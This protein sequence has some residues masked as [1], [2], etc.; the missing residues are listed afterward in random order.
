MAIPNELP[1]VCEQSRQGPK[2]VLKL[3]REDE[4]SPAKKDKHL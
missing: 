1:E 3:E 2:T 4:W